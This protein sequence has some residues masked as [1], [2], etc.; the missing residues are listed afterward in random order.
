V[1]SVAVIGSALQSPL[2]IYYRQMRFGRQRALQ[3][4]EPV[5]G[6]AVTAALGFAGAGVWSLVIGGV[7][8]HWTAGLVALKS[9]PYPIR[10]RFDRRMFGEYFSFS[11][12]I[13]LAAGSGA[14]M[15]QIGIIV[16]QRAIG[17]AG[18][19]AIG[20]AAT[21]ARFSERV[22]QILSQTMY[23]AIC[24]V[25]DQVD[26]LFESFVKS[27]RIAL[28][29]GTFVGFG[30]ALFAPDVVRW[31]VGEK[32]AFATGVIQVFGVLAAL[33]Q[34]AFNWTSYFLAIGN[35]RPLA[36][37]GALM[38]ATFVVVG[39]PLTIADGLTGYAIGMAVVAL[40]DLSVRAYYLTRLFSGFAMLRHAARAM[41]PSVPAVGAVLAARVIE[42]G[43]RTLGLAV[44]ELVLYAGVTA[45]A[46]WAFE[47]DL[48]R[49]LAGYLR[50]SRSKAPQPA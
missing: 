20:L 41:A 32:W 30:L 5:V 17:I 27:N 49:E 25:R 38:L 34:I 43:E 50:G 9:C 46:T 11:W 37:N 23:P 15:S 6:L 8:G 26:L 44:G 3:A 31:V 1:L 4:I 19:G 39:V 13:T 24:A 21:I 10:L 47:R 40:V 2:W 33:A 28:M 42:S 45:V 16:G 35:T 12:P 14:L 18:V 48:L 29:W 36:I 7:A 22:D